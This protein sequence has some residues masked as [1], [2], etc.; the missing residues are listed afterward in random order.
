MHHGSFVLGEAL[1]ARALVCLLA[2][3][4]GS[5]AHAQK[6]SPKTLESAAAASAPAQ[7][8]APYPAGVVTLA[9]GNASLAPAGAA[10]RVA[11]VGDLISE[12]DVL[13]TTKDGELHM[14]MQDTGFMALRPNSRLVVMHY[15]ADGGDDDKGVFSLVAGG[16]RSI[17]GWIGRFNTRAYQ[18]RTPTAT[19]GIRGTDHET[20]YIPEGSSEGDPGTYDKVYAGQTIIE[21]ADGATEVATDQ[22]G[23]VS[24]QPKDRPRLLAR[25]PGFFRPGPHE[26]EIAKKHDEIQSLID[27][28]RN[29]RRKVIAEKVL[30]LVAAREQF[31]TDLAQAR[32]TRQ[33]TNQAAKAQLGE[34]MAQREMLQQDAQTLQQRFDAWRAQR[35]ALQALV[36]SGQVSGVDLRQRRKALAAEHAALERAQA[37]LDARRKALQQSVDSKIDD[38]L[39]ADQERKQSLRK[40][41]KEVREKRQDV[42]A[43]RASAR[44]EIGTL[45]RQENLRLRRERKADS[46]RGG[47]VESSEPPTTPPP[48]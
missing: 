9:E 2:L 33:Q 20:R 46:A 23:F 12:G 21:T 3:G 31:K 32:D 29:E 13:V 10:P 37:E 24:L 27:Q 5:T 43:E 17:T 26:A 18:V 42:E 16:L 44:E 48:D 47:A 25:M 6:P 14:V 30:A 38:H 11:R 4:L 36:Q 19:I 8:Q 22:A 45:Q 39:K 35:E 34:A 28:R 1:R 40:E 41:F 15:K 7:P